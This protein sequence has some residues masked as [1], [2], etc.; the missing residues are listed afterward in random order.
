M[1]R[2]V[3][4]SIFGVAVALLVFLAIPSAQGP[5]LL[6]G[7]WKV[8]IAKSTSPGPPSKSDIRTYEDRGGGIVIVT[9]EI[10]SAQG[11]RS[12][13][14]IAMKFDGRDYPVL[15]RNAESST[16]ISYKRVD[17]FTMEYAVK[18]NG[19]VVS[20]TNSTLSKD[21][22]TMTHR[23]KGTSAQGEPTS[24]LLIFEKQ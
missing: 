12:Y 3:R 11:N 8:N 4:R 14:M 5:D 10:V 13:S 23:A 2:F 17:A 20:Q 16:T 24:T 21:G 6:M 1:N 9:V 22:K 7:T 19:K 15:S 18:E